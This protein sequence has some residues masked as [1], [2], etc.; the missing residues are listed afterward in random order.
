M[1]AKTA[2]NA[3]KVRNCFPGAIAIILPD[4]DCIVTSQL[5]KGMLTHACFYLSNVLSKKE[6]SAAAC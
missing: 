1:L 6:G 5:T 3:F 4:R 2:L